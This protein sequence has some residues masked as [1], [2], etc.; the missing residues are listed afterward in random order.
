MDKKSK[1]GQAPSVTDSSQGSFIYR[2]AQRLEVVLPQLIPY[3][4]AFLYMYTGWDKLNTMAAFVRGI[5]KI[6]YLGGVAEGIGW[7]IPLLELLLAL[8][9]IVPIRKVQRTA[10]QASTLLMAVFTLYLIAMVIF[11]PDR[12]CHCGGVIQ[13]MGW[14]THIAFNMIWLIAGMYALKKTKITNSKIH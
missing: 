6:P 3:G 13:S 7:G 5:R 11:V 12:L 14:K 2:S 8:L 9:L 10:L 4:F 1:G